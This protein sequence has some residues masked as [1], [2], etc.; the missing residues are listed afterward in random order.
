[1]NS[2]TNIGSFQY[3]VQTANRQKI[4]TQHR[5]TTYKGLTAQDN[6]L[7][8][9]TAAI[10]TYPVQNEAETLA[11][12]IT[13]M[14]GI[15]HMNIRYLAAALYL[16]NYNI[17]K[18]RGTNK[19]DSITSKMF[20][21]SSLPMKTIRDNLNINVKAESETKDVWRHRKENVLIYLI[22]ILQ[23]FSEDHQKY[24]PSK[25]YEVSKRKNKEE[26]KIQEANLIHEYGEGGGYDDSK[27]PAPEYD[28]ED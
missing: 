12:Q 24:K 26:E 23:Y 3:S 9:L 17:D 21:D 1:M 4:R 14:E 15:E 25:A 8:N 20:E 27:S 16:Y 7:K 10:Q 11:T 6:I 22:A 2:L 13:G 5:K 19:I 18:F 28:P